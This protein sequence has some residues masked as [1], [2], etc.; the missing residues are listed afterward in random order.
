MAVAF[1]QI[2]ER[3]SSGEEHL[4][5][6]PS[7]DR[8]SEMITYSSDH[9]TLQSQ[10]QLEVRDEQQH[11]TGIAHTIRRDKALL[12]HWLAAGSKDGKVSLWD[13]Y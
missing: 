9:E 7:S 3:A 6:E 5:S 2:A 13:I 11:S 8:G 1:A 10:Q 12:T 4:T